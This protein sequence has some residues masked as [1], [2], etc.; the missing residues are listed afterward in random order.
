MKSV[1]VETTIVSYLTARQSNDP[2]QSGRQEITQRWWT[3]ESSAFRLVTSEIV[4]EEASEG[5]ARAAALRLQKL[6][7]LERLVVTPDA[8][9]VARSL[10][11]TRA[12]PNEA[13]VD[14]L[15]IGIAAVHG[16]EYLLT[17]NFRHIAN[18]SLQA[19]IRQAI[20]DCGFVPPE[21]CTPEELYHG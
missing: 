13:I 5:D 4:V 10:I 17:W 14:A 12:I 21:I 19:L 18:A 1:Y 6:A 7:T 8:D 15:H 16:V 20:Y 11:N 9:E 2:I 3:R